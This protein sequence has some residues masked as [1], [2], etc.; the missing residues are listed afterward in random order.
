MK[1]KLI[2]HPIISFLVAGAIFSVGFIFCCNYIGKL[3]I[4][5]S[6]LFG[7]HQAPI[8]NVFIFINKNNEFEYGENSMTY[9]ATDH[10]T[11]LFRNDTVYFT[12]DNLKIHFKSDYLI[13][14]RAIQ[15]IY[16]NKYG[17]YEIKKNELSYK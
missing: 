10:G 12:S 6:L 16:G 11:Y 14:D 8:G 9:R 2:S 5:K 13:I 7:L 4:E 15:K 1:N 3:K 17:N